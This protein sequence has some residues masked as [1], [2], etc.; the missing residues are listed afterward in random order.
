MYAYELE[1]DDHVTVVIEQM[2]QFLFVLLKE[3]KIEFFNNSLVP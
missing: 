1:K 3:H 2:V